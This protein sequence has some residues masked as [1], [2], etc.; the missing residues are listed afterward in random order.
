MRKQK[1]YQ[2]DAFADKVFSGN[3][4][5]VCPFDQW[6]SDDIMQK[7]AMENNLA[8]KAFCLNGNHIRWKTVQ[9][10]IFDVKSRIVNNH[11]RELMHF[12]KPIN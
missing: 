1:I 12:I 7:I 10:C 3:P 4:A 6:L 9:L 5:A 11:D 8:E 2:I